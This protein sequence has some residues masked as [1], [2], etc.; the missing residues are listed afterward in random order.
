MVVRFHS[1]FLENKKSSKKTLSASKLVVRST[2]L[3]LINGAF[4]LCLT[5]VVWSVRHSLSVYIV[6]RLHTN[7]PLVGVNVRSSA[8]RKR[9]STLVSSGTFS[10]SQIKTSHLPE[11]SVENV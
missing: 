2:L 10:D 1:S 4:S 8:R 3:S 9:F 11:S 5:T 7:D 6:I